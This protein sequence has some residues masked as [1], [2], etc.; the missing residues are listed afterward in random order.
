[1][2]CNAWG[3]GEPGRWWSVMPTWRRII[4][5]WR[6]RGWILCSRATIW[7]RSTGNEND[8]PSGEP[9]EYW[10]QSRNRTTDTRIFKTNHYPASRWESPRKL[11]NFLAADRFRGR[12]RTSYRTF[13]PYRRPLGRFVEQHQWDAPRLTD[14]LPIW[15]WNRAGCPARLSI[16]AI[17]W[18]GTTTPLGIS[19]F[20]FGTISDAVFAASFSVCIE[21]LA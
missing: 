20:S 9:L 4:W 2:S 8:P 21:S 12:N 3:D 16:Y 6:L 7:L 10:W 13:V 14:P 17:F 19:T 5:R 18:N 1:M 15:Q 11:T